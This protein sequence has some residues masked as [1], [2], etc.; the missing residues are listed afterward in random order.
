MQTLGS[1]GE[2]CQGNRSSEDGRLAE[3]AKERRDASRPSCRA[4]NVFCCVIILFRDSVVKN[5]ES[6]WWLVRMR[7]NNNGSCNLGVEHTQPPS[8]HRT[9]LRC[10]ELVTAYCAG[11]QSIS[12]TTRPHCAYYRATA[13]PTSLLRRKLGFPT[14]CQTRPYQT[15]NPG[16]CTPTTACLGGRRVRLAENIGRVQILV[17]SG[18]IRYATP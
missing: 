8:M 14:S 15:N 1:G 2:P 10:G 12:C 16:R 18:R 5:V 7:G 4:G 3:K 9:R 6:R 13:L 17:V 11:N